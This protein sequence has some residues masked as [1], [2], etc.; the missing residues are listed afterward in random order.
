MQLCS[1]TAV[2]QTKATFT[3]R[4]SMSE[5]YDDNI[6]LDPDN[7][8]SDWITVVSPGANLQLESQHTQLKLDYEAG[9]SFY[10]QDSSRDTTRHRG[11]ISWDQLLAEHLRLNLNDTFS[12]SE[13][14][15][16]VED[17]RITDISN[18]RE[19]E[20]RNTG[21][22]SL[23]WQFGA[24]DIATLGY[25]NHLLDSRSDDTEDSR[26]N[27]GFFSLNKQFIPQF[28]MGLTS[29]ITRFEFQQSS[30]F[31]GEPTEDFYTYNAGL[32]MNYRWQ[33]QQTAYAS[34]SILYQNFDDEHATDDSNNYVVHRPAIGVNLS[35]GP[36]TALG[37]EVGYFRQDVNNENGEDGFVLN[38]SFNTQKER[39]T[40]SLQTNNGYEQD[41]G[42]SENRGFSQYSDNSA[43][44]GYQL[45]ENFNMF[46]S[47]SYRW[48]DFTETN[49]TDHTYGGRAGLTYSFRRWLSASL[50]GGHLR[51]DSD[52]K[53]DEFTDNRVTLRIT[54]SYPIPFG[55]N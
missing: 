6:D 27:E 12:R 32:T 28:G 36:N 5:T 22:A 39:T 50:E 9:F 30:G 43:R 29:G 44:V 15:I 17:D 46:A 34:Y 48:E 35:L 16:T 10:A 33:P 14:P 26:G 4:V 45:A 13:D 25:R 2:A 42:T 23:N 24:E 18:E 51:R 20:Y 37:V 40:F 7:E 19:V 47:A 1:G 41:Y 54:T 3:P 21:E 52:D 49:R 31:T 38:G 55:G 53:N 11:Q 8:E